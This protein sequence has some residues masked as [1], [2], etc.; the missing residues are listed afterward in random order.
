MFSP[1]DS[2]LTLMSIMTYFYAAL[3]LGMLGNISESLINLCAL[4]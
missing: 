1:W 4:Y 2:V 3:K